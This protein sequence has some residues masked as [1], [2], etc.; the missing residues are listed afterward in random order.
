MFTPSGAKDVGLIDEICSED[1]LVSK[2]EEILR[3]RF[4][5]IPKKARSEFKTAQREYVVKLRYE[6]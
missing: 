5:T 4:L 3:Q 6:K 1:L 2:A